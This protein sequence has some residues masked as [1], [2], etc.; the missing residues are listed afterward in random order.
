ML[1]SSSIEMKK[2]DR[3]RW[4]SATFGYEFVLP[5]RVVYEPYAA[6][7]AFDEFRRH[8]HEPSIR[9]DY[10]DGAEQGFSLPFVYPSATHEDFVRIWNEWGDRLVYIITEGVS[11]E[12]TRC[13]VSAQRL[14]QTS[15]LVEWDE[16]GCAQRAW[17]HVCMPLEHAFVEAGDDVDH[18]AHFALDPTCD[19]HYPIDPALGPLRTLRPRQLP[20]RTSFERMVNRIVA[21]PMSVDPLTVYTVR[22]D[23]KIVIW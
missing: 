23:G 7:V 14:S 2:L 10:K 5:H 19:G 8:G 6:L 18:D 12:E 17:E 4:I 16:G 11:P 3:M 13:N 21:L 20:S 9:T 15:F 22:Q 1:R